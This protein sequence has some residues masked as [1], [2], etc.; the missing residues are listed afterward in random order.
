MTRAALLSLAA[1]G[2]VLICLGCTGNGPGRDFS[3]KP[4]LDAEGDWTAHVAEDR[5]QVHVR[6]DQAGLFG[7]ALEVS[8]DGAHADVGP[9]AA[10]T[11]NGEPLQLGKALL[12][13]PL[14]V[15]RRSLELSQVAPDKHEIRTR[16]A[17]G[18]VTVVEVSGAEALGK[19]TLPIRIDGVELL[20]MDYGWVMRSPGHFSRDRVM[21][22]FILAEGKSQAI[23]LGADQSW[24]FEVDPDG[25]IAVVAAHRAATVR[26]F[27]GVAHRG[28]W[29]ALVQAY[30]EVAHPDWAVPGDPVR[31]RRLSTLV[32]RMVLDDWSGLPFDQVPPILDRLR[33][34]DCQNLVVVRHDWQHYGYD[35]KLP[36]TWPPRESFGGVTGLRKLADY[37]RAGGIPFGLHENFI[38]LYRDAPT[39][40]DWAIAYKPKEFHADGQL[41]EYKGWY[42]PGTQQQAVRQTPGAAL[43]AMQ[44]NVEQ[45]QQVQPSTIF[46]DVT[47]YIDPEPLRTSAGVYVGTEKVLEAGRD[48]YSRAAD[49]VRGPALGEGCTEK[50]LGAVQ[51][52]NCDLWN[53]D[54]W[55]NKIAPA[56]WE[57]F[58]LLDWLAHDRVVFQG[59]SYPCRYG[60]PAQVEFTQSL[61]E[62]PFLDDYNSTNVLFGHAPLYY[63]M[64]AGYSADPLRMAGM[65]WLS[66]P[67]SE[68]VGLQRIEDV[69]FSGGDIHRQIVRYTGGKQVWVN[70]SDTPWAVEGVVLPKYGYLARGS[71]VDQRLTLEAGQPLEVMRA[72]DILY[73][74]FRGHRR[75]YEA[76]RGRGR[77]PDR[78][79]HR[80][81]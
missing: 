34:L 47:S 65:Y 42:N 72:G 76:C 4:W 69:S 8:C 31:E 63:M 30:R 37:C 36:D 11:Y 6:L 9:L 56:D 77:C 81:R 13:R 14:S 23:L 79:R 67:L 46:M 60:V 49:A 18:E 22:N 44:R 3:G 17:A 32:G 43:R 10:K 12:S 15:Q 25:H 80:W 66:V 57:Y 39:F 26:F 24:R 45:E 54:R 51:G 75:T 64:S 73:V 70:R 61:Y 58:P 74:D 62:R 2:P 28:G 40:D 48:L 71:Q 1:I 19:L 21:T 68:D 35:V 33:F 38:D 29:A 50:F 41:H 20:A 78:P 53:V 7:N 55:G 5:V 52:A 59:V 16:V 27:V